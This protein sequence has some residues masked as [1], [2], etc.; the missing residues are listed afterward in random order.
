MT[1]RVRFQRTG[2]PSSTLFEEHIA[3][4]DPQ[5]RL[6]DCEVD[7]RDARGRGALWIEALPGP[8]GHATGDVFA[9][10]TP[11]IVTRRTR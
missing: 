5:M 2:K 10:S 9:I 3:Y 11:C 6:L 4:D 7:L 1:F 8:A